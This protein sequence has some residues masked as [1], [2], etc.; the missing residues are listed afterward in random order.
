MAVAERGGGLAQQ[1]EDLRARLARQTEATSRI[2]ASL[3]FETVLQGVLDSACS[4]TGARYGLVFVVDESGALQHWLTSGLSAGEHEQ[5]MDLPQG[6][7]LLSH[8]VGVV[9]PRR[10]EDFHQYTTSVGFADFR[11]P[12]PL[13]SPV[14]VLMAPIHSDGSCVGN[15][16][17]AGSA[18]FV[19]AC[20]TGPRGSCPCGGACRVRCEPLRLT[21]FDG[22]LR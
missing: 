15:I 8:L 20:G 6:P 19:R 22:H 4:L 11:L 16:Y 17:L 2:T 18:A 3:D 12:L 13:E 21:R 10:F 14:T 5:F 1:V 7:A 9:G